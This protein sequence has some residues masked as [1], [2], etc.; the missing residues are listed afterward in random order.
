MLG[1][2][3]AGLLGRMAL[4][5]DCLGE[6]AVQAGVD[7]FFVAEEPVLMYCLSLD[8]VEGVGEQLGRFAEGPSVNLALDALFGGGVEGDGHGMSINRRRR[9][10]LDAKTKLG[11]S[12]YQWVRKRGQVTRTEIPRIFNHR[13]RF[14][15][16]YR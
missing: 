4:A 15:D 2:E 16:T 1:E 9:D 7:G 14:E 12:S 6:G 13:Y 3:G 11:N 10:R 5:A 8:E